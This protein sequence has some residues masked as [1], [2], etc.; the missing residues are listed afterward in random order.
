MAAAVVMFCVFMYHHKDVSCSFL[1]LSI[2]YTTAACLQLAIALHLV[3][4]NRCGSGTSFGRILLPA[5]LVET[6]YE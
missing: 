2:H 4:G 1:L 6:M 3:K 5:L